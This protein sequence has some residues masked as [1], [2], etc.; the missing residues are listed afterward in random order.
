MLLVL[1]WHSV[2]V[3][4]QPPTTRY[5]QQAVMAPAMPSNP[6]AD[7]GSN[8]N[9][10]APMEPTSIAAADAAVVTPTTVTTT[11]TEPIAVW[12]LKTFA[13][14][15]LLD[16]ITGMITLSPLWPWMRHMESVPSHRFTFY[17]SLLDLAIL[18]GL[19][20]VA[21]K[22]ALLS[23]YYWWK[24]ADE[25]DGSS[26]TDSVNLFHPNGER[27]TREQLEQEALEEPLWPWLQR[28]VCRPSF[29]AEVLAVVTQSVCIVKCLLRMNVEI[30]TLHDE[31]PF[32]PVFWLA[33]LLTAILSVL[34]ATYLQEI[35]KVAG[36][37]GK[38][39]G[40]QAPAILRTIS[41]QL[42]APLLSE[43]NQGNDDEEQT[44]GATTTS[45]EDDENARAASDI[46]SDPSY[47][48][49]WSDVLMIC[50][51][52]MHLIGIAFVFLLLAAVAQVYIPKFLGN[53]LDALAAAFANPNDSN[54]NMSMW[55]VPHFM[56]NVKLLV[57]A[58]VCAGVFAGL[59]GSI[60][61][62]L[63]RSSC[64]VTP[65]DRRKML[66]SQ[67]FCCLQTVVG[68]RINVRLRVKLMDA[69][70]SQDIGFFDITKTGDITSRLS[71]DTTLVGDQISL[72]VN[73]FL[74]SLVQA[75][76]VL[77]FMLMVSWQLTVLAFISV[78]LITLLSKWYG[79]YVR[80]LTKVMQ[81]KLADGNAVSE[82]ALGSMATVRAFDAAEKELSD[83][84]DCMSKYLQ[85]NLKSAIAYNGYATLATTLPELIF[86]VVG[87][88]FDLL[89]FTI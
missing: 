37:Y 55:E 84:E 18:S 80:S 35:C 6:D 59:R 46:T 34:E 36:Q 40:S 41:S 49:N 33:I 15:L 54:R 29:S 4:F 11:T 77:L 26:G 28:F 67:S 60:F 76:G 53:I 22:L 74:R 86:A 64:L 12:K 48:A 65:T 89:V 45:S 71:S 56:S 24:P 25:A 16:M 1:L 39:T 87:K 2:I 8:S 3:I 17:T 88:C 13:C 21:C 27:K 68:A 73:V 30:G 38:E 66:N 85:L 47:K 20:V 57:I 63:H 72:N 82:A 14:V 75:I 42:L 62:S 50:Y 52:D 10:A 23:S 83:F 69:L 51:H 32:H 78:P 79:D 31:Q 9:D 70:L 5:L 61:V 44:N 58:S 7:D 43:E 19:R 81:Q